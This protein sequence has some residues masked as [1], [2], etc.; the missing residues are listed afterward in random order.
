[1]NPMVRAVCV[2]ADV[3]AGNPGTFA[4]QQADSHAALWECPFPPAITMAVT[5]EFVCLRLTGRRTDRYLE[6]TNVDLGTYTWPT[7]QPTLWH[8]T[9]GQIHAAAGRADRTRELAAQLE[10]APAHIRWRETGARW[11]NGLAAE[12]SGDLPEAARQLGEAHARGM[13]ELRIHAV[14]LAADLARVRRAQGDKAGAAEAQR[15]SDSRLARIEGARYLI[16]AADDPLA[17]LSDRERQVVGLLTQ[18]LSYAQIATELSVS[19][20]TVGFHL[21]NIYA[22]TETASRHELTELVRRG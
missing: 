1:V 20:S 5:A 8:L 10:A 12:A 14:L 15:E 18:G 6:T 17:A 21:S 22:K 2:L 16:A 13:S 9:L 3:A 19:R 11:L 4:R 7:A